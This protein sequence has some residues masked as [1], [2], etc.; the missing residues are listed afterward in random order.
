MKYLAVILITIMLGGCGVKFHTMQ[1]KSTDFSKYKTFCWLQG[2]EFTYSGPSYLN[3]SLWRE[4]I[5]ESIITELAEKGITMDENDPDLLIDF[6]I[7]V[8]NETSVQYRQNEGYYQYQP[9]PETEDEVINYLK[10][11]MV[12]H[13]VDKAEGKIV[14]RSESIG[15]LD[16][17]PQLTERNIKKGIKLTLKKFPPEG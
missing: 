16:V 11:T 3:D 15:Y 2:C 6:Q 13:I 1:D 7:A 10:G 17:N 9:F 4:R 5:K 12:I 8:E 14:W